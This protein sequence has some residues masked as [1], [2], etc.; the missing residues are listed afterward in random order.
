MGRNVVNEHFV[1]EDGATLEDYFARRDKTAVHHLIRYR[2]AAAVLAEMRCAG[3]ILDVAC[4]AGYGSYELSNH[5]P[6]LEVVGA[7][8]DKEAVSFARDRYKRPNLSFAR[9]DLTQWEGQV[10]DRRFG[11]IISFDTLE[12][13][14]HREIMMQNIVE[15][16][17]P[18][19]ILLLSTPVRA[20]N[21]LNPSWDHH[22]IEYSRVSLHD[23]LRRYFR[24]VLAND[25][26]TLPCVGVFDSINR[27]E[28]FYLLKMNPL[29]C[30]RPIRIEFGK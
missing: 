24:E 19:G 30:R 25:F 10:G 7:D 15:H 26:G 20:E 18:A 16:L 5:F 29:L 17:H 27:D 9:L 4:G 14:E 12:H 28:V 2:W 8:Y 21:V 22:E 23:F 13:I 1:P 11:C 6:G 3:P